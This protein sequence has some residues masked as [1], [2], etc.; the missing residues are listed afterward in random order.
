MPPTEG[1]MAGRCTS[2][3]SGRP[4]TRWPSTTRGCSWTSS[5]AARSTGR[6]W[7]TSP[8]WSASRGAGRSSTSAAAGP[9]PART[10]SQPSVSTSPASTSRRGW[11][12]RRSGRYPEITF[13][14]GTLTCSTSPTHRWLAIVRGTPSSTPRPRCCPRSCSSCTHVIRPN[15]LLLLAFRR[16]DSRAP[17]AGIRSRGD[18]GGAPTRSRPRDRPARGCRFRVTVRTERAAQDHEKTPQAFLL[19]R[20]R[21]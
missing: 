13:P 10:L 2:P 19:A 7:G 12:P 15:G 21:G 16:V 18:L 17:R 14:P 3:E 4:T 20:R 5:R 6:F 11:S 1:G 9:G 8:S